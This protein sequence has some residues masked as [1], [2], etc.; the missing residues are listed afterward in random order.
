MYS[1]SYF[2]PPTN[3]QQDICSF[4]GVIGLLLSLT[5][6]VQ[7]MIYG[8]S[9]WLVPVLMGIYIFTAIAFLLLVL[10]KPVAPLLLIISAVLLLLAEL[11]WIRARS[12]SLVVLLLF[13]YCVLAVIFIYIE[14]VPAALR[15]K[16]L[17][18]REEAEQWRGKI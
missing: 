8:T 17:A 5:C 11:I 7:L 18:L 13:L 2:N 16:Q 1:S 10:Q 9:Y 12:F 15:Q 14:Q 3:R 6:L 4:G